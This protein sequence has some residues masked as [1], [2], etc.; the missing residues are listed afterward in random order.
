MESFL[1]ILWLVIAVA[2]FAIWQLCLVHQKRQA[3]REPLKEWTAVVCMLVFVFF[4]VSL[5]DDLHS[6][7]ILF[8]ECSAGRR[9]WAHAN[10]A[11]HPAMVPT[12]GMAAIQPQNIR[13]ERPLLAGP[14]ASAPPLEAH[15]RALEIS[16]GRSPPGL[17][18]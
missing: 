9:T 6:D 15:E 14:V 1:N 17:S 4:A 3:Q 2:A 13:L 16:S 10:N 11:A 12:G 8:D 5:T 7:L 18:L